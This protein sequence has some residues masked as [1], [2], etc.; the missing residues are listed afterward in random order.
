MQAGVRL[1]IF[2]VLY[3]Q[4]DE[5][6]ANNL[7]SPPAPQ[8]EGL[9]PEEM[10]SAGEQPAETEQDIQDACSPPLQDQEQV[11]DF[12]TIFL[13]LEISEPERRRLSITT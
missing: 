3:Q 13:P 2:T 10:F 9:R 11:A 12:C 7:E 4:A 1:L 5:N 8:G 6:E